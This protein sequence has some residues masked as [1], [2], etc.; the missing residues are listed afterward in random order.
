MADTDPATYSY[1][2]Y[3]RGGAAAAID[4]ADTTA[5]P[6]RARA[7]LT[8]ALSDGTSTTVG[9]AVYGPG[10]VVRLD[11]SQILRVDPAS[12]T[13]GHLPNYFPLV[14]FDRPE[15]PWL[16]S[17]V[18]PSGDQLRPW[19]TLVV[20]RQRD[21]VTLGVG[22]TGE[23]LPVLHIQAPCPPGEELPALSDAWA[24]AHVQALGDVAGSALGG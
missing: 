13:S 12:D 23:Q 4:Q 22:S 15:L 14:E 1:F 11:T 24:W 7:D 5:T 19:L 3:A 16:F 10:D 21:G 20:V 9:V 2:A 17:P 6:S 8:I 18:P